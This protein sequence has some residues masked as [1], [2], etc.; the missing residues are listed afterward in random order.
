MSIQSFEQ[1]MKKLSSMS[2]GIYQS[3]RNIFIVENSMAIV[4]HLILRQSKTSLVKGLSVL[5]EMIFH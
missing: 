5:H 2:I 3:Q 1:I 4:S